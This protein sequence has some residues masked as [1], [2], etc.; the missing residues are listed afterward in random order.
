VST[1]HTV[2]TDQFGRVHDYLRISLTERCNLRCTY[3][4]P[5]EG[6]QLKPQ[7]QFMTRDELLYLA[8]TFTELGVKKIRLTG[9]EPLVRNDAADI[10][11]GLG[12]LPVSLAISTN[13]ILVDKFVG[14]FQKCG[15]RSVNV[16]LDSLNAERFNAV[17]RRNYFEKVM[18]NIHLLL[19]EHFHVKLNAVVM[20]GV[21]DDE[22]LQFIEFTKD[23]HLHVRF[24]EFM[25]FNGNR[26][27]WSKGLSYK[28]IMDRVNTR[29][30]DA[31]V[32]LSDAEND[33][34]K[35]Y[36][37][38]GYKGTF[39]IISSVTNPFCDTCNRLRLTAD[40]KMK[41]CLFSQTETDLLTAL[42]LGHDVKPLIYESVRNK[43]PVRGGMD[44]FGELSDPERNQ[45]NRSMITI[46]G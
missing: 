18:A 4:M 24:I 22:L 5:A 12:Q 3:C 46:G 31:V 45:Q 35:A 39:A 21:N 28:D 32:K 20:K 26:W 43:K 36:Q 2:L 30:G 16:S 44:T 1:T 19:D 9:G 17:T 13:G 42:R 25:P 34:A 14:T 8:K 27:D 10:I 37:V 6:V 40:G 15:L 11:E 38:K 23:K 7:A 41:N 29:Y 33:T